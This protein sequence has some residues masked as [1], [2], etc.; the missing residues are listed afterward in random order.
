MK[1]AAISALVFVAVIGAWLFYGR[2]PV[3]QYDHLEANARKI[4]TALELQAW[5]TNLLA[6]NPTGTNLVPSNWGSNFPKQLSSLC[7][8]TG[9]GVCVYEPWEANGE[10]GPGWVRVMWGSGMLG[11]S[12]F[13]IGPTNFVSMQPGHAWAPSPHIPM[14][15]PS[16]WR[17]S[18]CGTPPCHRP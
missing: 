5:A 11:A 9:P 4:V 10:K 16:A 6:T 17:H 15:S 18:P 12:G 13:E 2:K 8:K 7:P 14:S 1:R 3:W